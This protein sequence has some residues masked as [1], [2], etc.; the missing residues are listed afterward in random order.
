MT[1]AVMWFRRDL[2]L[3]DNPALLAACAAADRVL[4]VFVLDPAFGGRSSARLNRLR[5]SLAALWAQTDGALVVRSG[6]PAAVIG[7][8]AD[9]VAADEVHVT[10]ETTPYGRSRDALVQ[11]A[12]A[13]A[14]RRLV[15]T[16]TPYAV[17]PGRVHTSGGTPYRVFTPYRAAWAANGWPAPADEVDPRWRRGVAGEEVVRGASAGVGENAALE[18]WWTFLRMDLPDYG[19]HRDRPDLDV[20]SGMS[21][22]LKYGE[23]H[24]RTMLADLARE[25]DTAGSAA[26]K[27]DSIRRYVTELAW[28]E[29]YADVLW[30]S[31]ESAWGDWRADF[32]RM[33]YDDDEEAI[34]AW[35]DGRTGFPLVD[36]GM[37]QL[38]EQGWMHNRVRMVTASF[39]V[40]D[41]H[42][43][44]PVGARHFMDHLQD[45]DLASNSHGWQWVAGTGTDA[46]PYY[47]I[48]NPI[49]QGLRF[50]PEG[51][52]VRRW[53]PELR[54]LRGAAAHEPWRHEDGYAGGYSPRMIDHAQERRES[55]LR[56]D[57]LR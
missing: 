23:I 39:L 34:Q 37:R 28:R 52:Y 6:E 24:P 43:W 9:E 15:V 47:R 40:K 49:R 32:A 27:T 48:F 44:W 50:D 51:D 13:A 5:D 41:L 29:F 25:K 12:L 20:T 38:R 18:R 8:I 2:R 22:P 35:R 30:H 45:G 26:G 16:G 31:P 53:L 33:R 46:A 17:A 7:E 42:M 55:L 57:E 56:L 54:H 3:G 11:R 36:A 19:E 1:T 10:G 4:P 21:V 14:G